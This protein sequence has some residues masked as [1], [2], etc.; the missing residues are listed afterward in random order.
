MQRYK[1]KD[2]NVFMKPV[3]VQS[4]ETIKHA[5]PRLS[6]S[7][8]NDT[9]T[10]ITCLISA[11]EVKDIRYDI[12][13]Y[14]EFLK[15]VP[16]RLGTNSALDASALALSSTYAS[17]STHQ[18]S[19]KTVAAYVNALQAVRASLSDPVQARTTDTLCAI[20]MVMICQVGTI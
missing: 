9:T 6:R 16:R 14:G 10:T 13:C 5:L 20:Y 18:A 8:S 3:K 19:P 11:L 12:T 15:H 2:H 4:A 7:P 17:L 1:F